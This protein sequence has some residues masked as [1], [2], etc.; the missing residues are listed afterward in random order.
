MKKLY[1]LLLASATL[2]LFSAN[3]QTISTFENITLPADSFWDGRYDLTAGG[4]NSGNAFF[5]NSYDTAYD[6]W[7]GGFMVSNRTDSSTSSATSA[8]SKLVT[9]V[10]GSGYNSATY[11]IGTQL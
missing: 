9:A 4:F 7:S 8:F 6:F 2:S 3:A 10:A 1:F 11:A 5:T